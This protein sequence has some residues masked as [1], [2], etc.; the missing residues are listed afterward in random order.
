MAKKVKGPKTEPPAAVVLAAIIVTV[1]PMAALLC[2]IAWRIAA[3][4]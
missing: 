4:Q 1:G 3:C 2:A